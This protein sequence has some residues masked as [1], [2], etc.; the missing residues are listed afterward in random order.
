MRK[1]IQNLFALEVRQ[2]TYYVLAVM[3]GKQGCKHFKRPTL[4]EFDCRL[5]HQS[6]CV[7]HR[8]PEDHLCTHLPAHKSIPKDVPGMPGMPGQSNSASN[9]LQPPMPTPLFSKKEKL[10]LVI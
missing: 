4:M 10:H 8:T 9:A 3:C 2:G 1:R 5:C 7:K 6:F